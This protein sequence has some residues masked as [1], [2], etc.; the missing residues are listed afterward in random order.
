MVTTSGVGT[1]SRALRAVALPGTF[2]QYAEADPELDRPDGP[3]RRLANLRRYLALFGGARYLLIGEAAGYAACRFS[4]VPFTDERQL[5]GP[6]AL[7]WAGA[8]QGFARA[9]RASRPL[10]REASATLV[11]ATLGQRRDVALWNV[12]PWHPVGAGGPLSNAPPNRPARAA[13]LEL[14]R[15]VLVEIWPAA[16]PIAV[17]RVAE[18]A[19]QSLGLPTP[20]YLR[21]PAHGGGPAF[22]S[23]LAAAVRPAALP[24]PPTSRRR[25]G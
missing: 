2:N 7:S 6:A 1:V 9:S 20:V 10:L 8:D 25:S 15:L 11:W 24:A 19:L 3:A 12:V 16:Q 4:G 23:G 13:G 17:G 21:H 22:R 5:I 18:Q 14:L